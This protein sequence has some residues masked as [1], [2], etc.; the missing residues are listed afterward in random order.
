VGGP[1]RT[2]SFGIGAAFL[3]TDLVVTLLCLG[4][5]LCPCHLSDNKGVEV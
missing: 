2:C 4:F 5:I 1:S 3:I